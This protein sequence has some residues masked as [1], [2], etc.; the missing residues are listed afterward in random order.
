MSCLVLQII[1]T[2]YTERPRQMYVSS[3]GQRSH[4]TPANLEL[5]EVKL[6]R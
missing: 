5:Q 6:E 2:H 4:V 1:L 3:V